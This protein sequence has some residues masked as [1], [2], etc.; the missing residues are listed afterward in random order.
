MFQSVNDLYG[1]LLDLLQY[2]NMC[3][4]LGSEELNLALQMSLTRAEAMDDL[5]DLQVI[6]FLMQARMLLVFFA[7]GDKPA[8]YL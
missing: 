2:M 7:T 3:L 4:V 1:P 5:L 6:L 8:L